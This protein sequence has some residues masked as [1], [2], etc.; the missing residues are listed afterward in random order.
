MTEQ[1]FELLSSGPSGPTFGLLAVQYVPAVWHQVHP[2]L[3]E[4]G[5]RLLEVYSLEELFTEVMKGSHD[6]WIAGED[7]VADGVVIGVWERHANASYYHIV[8]CA[9]KQLEKYLD[10]GLEMLERYACMGGA[11]EIIVEGRWGWK[12]RLCKRGYVQ[13]SVKLRKSVKVL[14]S[15]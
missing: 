9:G 8:F 5:K 14:W 10:K 11:K 2:L 1:E 13:T 12:R 4:Y 15:N 3:L 7:G 6:L